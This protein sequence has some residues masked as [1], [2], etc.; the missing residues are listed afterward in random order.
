MTFW[1][2]VKRH[3]SAEKEKRR[4]EEQEESTGA[5]P[6]SGAGK[7]VLAGLIGSFLFLILLF[8]LHWPFPVALL[9]GLGIT[10]ALQFLTKS[11]ERIGTT[12]IDR[13]EQGEE[14]L[15]LYRATRKTMDEMRQWQYRITDGKLF[16]QADELVRVGADIFYYLTRHP[17]K[18]LPS[19]QFLTYY[20]ETANRI[21]QNYVEMQNAH[22][23]EE[24][25][26]SIRE[27]T[28][29]SVDYLHTIFVNQRDGYHRDA[30][31]NLEE[32]S[33]LL[34]KTITMGG[35]RK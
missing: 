1:D 18:I 30:M 27:Q 23:S 34:E 3:L 13:L 25:F 21:F 22:L 31:Q 11:V 12:P 26:L 17:E 32:E 29:T 16:K 6:K 19:R 35:G 10:V 2:H 15:L 24:K 28:A 7:T 5:A 8:L 9:L 33:E 14:A 4:Q 20:L